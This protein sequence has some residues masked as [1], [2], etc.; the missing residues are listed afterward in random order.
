MCFQIAKTFEAYF[1]E[2]M[3]KS[4]FYNCKECIIFIFFDF[5]GFYLIL[6]CFSR[7]RASTRP[8]HSQASSCRENHGKT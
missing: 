4:I 5:R 6:M 1:P 7:Q 3:F 2:T 8:E